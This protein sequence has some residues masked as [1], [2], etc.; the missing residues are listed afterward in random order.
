MSGLPGISDR[1]VTRS[2][3]AGTVAIARRALVSASLAG[4]VLVE[5]ASYAAL[6]FG[7]ASVGGPGWIEVALAIAL[8][9]SAIVIW[10]LLLAPTARRWLTDPAALLLE[11]AVFAGA[12]LALATA[13]QA[14]GAVVLGVVGGANAV[15][16]RL[17]GLTKPGGQSRT[18]RAI[19]GR[20]SA[21]EDQ[22]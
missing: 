13:G 14:A 12:A 2:S 10:A 17:L 6:G 16:L 18:S 5:L 4:R 1:G 11:L 9:A 7:G 8:P 21:K 19:V 20:V 15:A 22:S 3:A